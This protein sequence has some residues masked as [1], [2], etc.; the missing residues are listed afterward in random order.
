MI[1]WPCCRTVNCSPRPSPDW[2]GNASCR[3][4]RASP[5][6]ASWWH[7]TLRQAGHRR[8]QLR[9]QMNTRARG[10]WRARGQRTIWQ[11]A[12]IPEAYWS[13]EP[14]GLLTGL[15]STTE[16]LTQAEA[17]ARL[18]EYGPNALQERRHATALTL[19]LGQFRSPLVLILVFAAIV[20][21]A[22]GE[23]VDAS[24]VLAVVLGSTI[25]GFTQ[26]YMASNA[27]EKLR[28]QVT[29]KSAVVRDGVTLAV[30]SEEIVPGDVV[31]LSAGSLIPADGILLGSQ[32]LF[33]N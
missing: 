2:R 16:G 15:A 23:W 22:L 1:C 30:P 19:F 24:I 4:S 25:L 33:V 21:A 6:C 29:I 8:R 28:S 12:S 20:S 11:H 7:N 18:K 31:N 32:D 5:Q 3:M 14:G 27:V 17:A 13:A 10:L 9:R 26:E